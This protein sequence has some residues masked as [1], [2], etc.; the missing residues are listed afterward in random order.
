MKTI[1]LTQG[2][3]ALVDDDDFEWLSTWK[4][5]A[6]KHRKTYYACTNIPGEI[7]RGIKMH[8]LLTIYPSKPLM[9]DHVNHNGLDN[10]RHNLRVCTN[11]INQS[12]KLYQG[13]SEYVGVH[14]SKISKKW[15]SRI[16]INGNQ[17]NLGF[18]GTETDA[19]IAY[20]MALVEWE[21]YEKLPCPRKKT[22]KYKGV[23]WYKPSK[24][25]A[26]R[27]WTDKKRVHIGYFEN[28]LDANNAYQNALAKHLKRELV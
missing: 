6:W 26:A 22:S 10:R 23:C 8:Q 21:M 4:W 12:N 18:F 28:E 20:R 9:V 24:K 17:Y 14:W 7:R 11:R 16:T 19:D 5:C 13:V 15:N 3:V 2:R 27:I 25:W 1:E